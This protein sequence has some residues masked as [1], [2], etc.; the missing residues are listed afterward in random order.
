MSASPSPLKPFGYA[1]DV[2]MPRPPASADPPRLTGK[3]IGYRG[4]TLDG[5]RLVSANARQHA[6]WWK[7]GPNKAECRLEQRIA[8]ITQLGGPIAAQ[9]LWQQVRSAGVHNAPHP[10]CECG[11]Y[12]YFDVCREH[13][14]HFFA[15]AKSFVWGAIAAW[16][17]VEVHAGG[18]RAEYAEPIALGYDP[19]DPPE[20]VGKHRAIAEE[21]GLPFV[22]FDELQAEA[23]KHGQL[24][25]EDLRP[26]YTSPLPGMFSQ[27]SANLAAMS[28]MGVSMH[29]A[30]KK[31]EEAQAA[32]THT[33][34]AM[35]PITIKEMRELFAPLAHAAPSAIS[36]P[37]KSKG[38]KAT[39]KTSGPPFTG[40]WR[41]HDMVKDRKGDYWTCTASGTPG[42]WERA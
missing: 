13:N 1:L 40:R 38:V 15:T 23:V 41:E 28:V 16:G 20:Q 25:P 11:L 8:Y 21:L 27:L 26:E 14:P 22:P 36:K 18:F 31:F 37:R 7:I 9:H 35:E 5:Y 4:W 12:A 30:A 24:V 6:G 17:H 2:E 39:L 34:I 19:G 10:N 33:L 42:S 29:H 32:L 3:I